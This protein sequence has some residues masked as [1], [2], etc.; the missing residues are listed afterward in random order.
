MLLLTKILQVDAYLTSLIAKETNAPG[1]PKL[2]VGGIGNLPS[3]DLDIG[4]AI[5]NDAAE[6]NACLISASE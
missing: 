2:G 6:P 5:K 4:A 3:P 1:H